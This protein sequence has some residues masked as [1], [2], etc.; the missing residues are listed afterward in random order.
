[1]SFQATQR[2]TTS[3]S[4]SS[5]L[6]QVGGRARFVARLCDGDDVECVV[7][8]TI[9]A[10]VQSVSFSSPG[11][12]RN[13]RGPVGRRKSGLRWEPTHVA[14]FTKYSRSDDRAD[15][16][17]V[18]KCRFRLTYEVS[19]LPLQGL[20]FGIQC[21]EP[22]DTATA[23]VGAA[24]LI[25][26]YE[27]QGREKCTPAG[28]HAPERA[29]IPG[30]GDRHVGVKAIG[31]PGALVEELVSVVHQELEILRDAGLT[32]RGQIRFAQHDPSD[33]QRVTRIRL[34]AST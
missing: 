10:A 26:Y 1:M 17:D 32:Y 27:R 23:E 30:V 29:L 7:Q 34:S 5:P 3:L 31:D 14:H 12:S 13:R 2:L 33:R 8:T 11:R 19:N 15:A 9:P 16:T 28:E 20:A 6:S 25:A 4:F 24:G 22:F 18:H 21:K